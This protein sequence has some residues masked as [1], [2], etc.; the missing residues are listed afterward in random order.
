MRKAEEETDPPARS[1]VTD[2]HLEPYNAQDLSRLSLFGGVEVGKDRQFARPHLLIG[3]AHGFCT[4][5]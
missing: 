5:G 3:T 1:Q 2:E 4:G